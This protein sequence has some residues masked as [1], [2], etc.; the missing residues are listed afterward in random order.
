M[1]AHDAQKIFGNPSMRG[2]ANFFDARN[3]RQNHAKQDVVVLFS[4]GALPLASAACP[5][6]PAIHDCRH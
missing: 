2:Q 6:S 3:S 1:I 4:I 5:A